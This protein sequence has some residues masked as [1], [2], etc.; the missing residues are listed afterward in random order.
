MK[1]MNPDTLE[2]TKYSTKTRIFSDSKGLYVSAVMVQPRES[3]VERLTPRDVSVNADTFYTMIDSSGEGLYGYTFGLSLGGS[4]QDGKIA[5]ERVMSFE[6]DGPWVG[7]TVKTSD[8]WS[9][10][11][12]F[13]W[14]VLSM[15]D[16]KGVRKLGLLIGRRVAHL[17]E[18]WGWPSFHF[19]GPDLYRG[20]LRNS[21]R[22]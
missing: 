19:R 22:R 20:S 2:D 11:M 14:S 1:V 18:L 9:A 7:E 5:P 16:A 10:E 6:W 3:L 21:R 15:P 12:F 8:G 13:P 4:K 17:D